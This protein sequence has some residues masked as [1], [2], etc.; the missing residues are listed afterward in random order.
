[1][2]VEQLAIP[3]VLAVTPD[4]HGDSRGFFS[5]TYNQRVFA[6]HGIDALFVQDNHS[7]SGLKGTI[8]G[9]HFQKPPLAQAKLVRVVRG[10]VYDVAVD[11]RRGSPTY[12]RFAGATLSAENGMQLYVP[13][14]FAHGFCTLA[15]ET[16]VVYKVSD[17]Y[18]REHDAALFWDDP[19]I[20][21]P[22][23]LDGGSA[24]ISEKDA[25]APRFTAFESPFVY[26]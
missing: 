6:E 17:F 23:P 12:G 2:K 4:R 21:I 19:D 25:A 13:I 16:E 15:D 20:R 5:E 10:A 24:Q 14:G 18:S 22:W 3:A 26:E 11:I 7:L 1:M 9:L 8:R